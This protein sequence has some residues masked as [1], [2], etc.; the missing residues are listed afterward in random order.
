MR[1][2]PGFRWGFHMCRFVAW[3]GSQ[4]YLDELIFEQEQSLVEQS[5]NALI[6]KTPINAD[7]FGLAWY[8]GRETPCV[9][10]DTHPAWSNA[11]LR[12]IAHHT[13]SGL[14]LAHIRASTGMA[15]SWN[16]CHPFAVGKWSFMHNGQ[17]G[18]HKK[19]RQALDAL[20]PAELYQF[21]YGATDSE[22][23]FLIALGLG[24]EENPSKAMESAVGL[25]QALAE[26]S[27]EHPYMRFAACWSDGKR[28]FAGRMASDQLAPSLYFKEC[29]KGHII[30]SEPLDKNEGNWVE[31]PA[32]E[33]IE[34]REGGLLIS[35]AFGT[36]GSTYHSQGSSNTDTSYFRGDGIE[37]ITTTVQS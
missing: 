13:Q 34:I 28:L 3:H 16:N 21:R 2:L 10:K 4:R 14:F 37:G 6:G 25:V 19:F 24:L 36:S 11:N 1:A 33:A 20:I 35:H 26:K 7:G 29:S 22:A 9:Y 15:T 32:G 23:I 12:Q 8:Q 30:S 17:A 27:G 31:L 18:G 5:K